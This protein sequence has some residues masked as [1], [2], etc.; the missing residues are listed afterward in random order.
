MSYSFSPEVSVNSHTFN[1]NHI[2]PN[3]SGT[4][5]MLIC[6]FQ[7]PRNGSVCIRNI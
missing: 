4:F 5:N 7:D 6:Y 1:K 2:S 3:M